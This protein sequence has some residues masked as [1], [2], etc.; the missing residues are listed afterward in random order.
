MCPGCGPLPV[1]ATDRGPPALVFGPIGAHRVRA[2]R[3]LGQVEPPFWNPDPN[4][5][6][7]ARGAAATGLVSHCSHGASPSLRARRG[8]GTAS[9][10]VQTK[11]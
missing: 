10:P 9:R 8:S 3:V 5:T 1:A 6:E 7:P 4:T 2:L 11:C